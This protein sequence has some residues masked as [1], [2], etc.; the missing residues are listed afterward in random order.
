M[1]F[2]T[3]RGKSTKSTLKLKLI[4]RTQ[5]QTVCPSG[6]GPSPMVG[7]RSANWQLMSQTWS[8]D[9]WAVRDFK[10][11]HY[12]TFKHGQI[13]HAKSRS[14]LSL[15]W[16]TGFWEHLLCVDGLPLPRFPQALL[17]SA[18]PTSL[19]PSFLW[20]VG[21]EG[22]QRCLWEDRCTQ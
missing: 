18:A 1:K 2:S 12:I 13:S 5:T 3:T 10:T 11:T 21:T 17:I 14:A 9:V 16:V 8:G 15:K 4:L 20:L 22:W 19:L 7:I 6:T